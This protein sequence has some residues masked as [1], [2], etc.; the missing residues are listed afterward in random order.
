MDIANLIIMKKLLTLLSF[1]FLITSCAKDGEDGAPGAQGPAGN[2][3]VKSF[4]FMVTPGQW[5]AT[6]GVGVD[7]ERYVDLSVAEVTQDIVDNGAVL[8]Y[9]KSSG[10]AVQLPVTF[11]TGG[12]TLN[13]LSSFSVGTVSLEYYFSN[14]SSFTVNQN[15]DFKVI[16]IDGTLRLQHPE[17]DWT[18]SKS[19]ALG[20]NLD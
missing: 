6:G 1:T 7:Y 2:A 14:F 15:F 4:N 17:I 9:W 12:N 18:D 3:N 5:Q 10:S 13:L 19:I 11:P 20:L 16:V 8:V